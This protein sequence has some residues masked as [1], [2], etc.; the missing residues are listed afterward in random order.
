ML[1][2]ATGQARARGIRWLVASA[3]PP[4]HRSPNGK[5]LTQHR[6]P[7]PV[8]SSCLLRRRQPPSPPPT[9]ELPSPPLTVV[10]AGAESPSSPPAT[11]PP[12]PPLASELPSPP[13][14]IE[15]TS[16][17]PT[18]VSAG[19]ESP[20]PPPTVVST[21][22]ESPDIAA[23][24]PSSSRHP[25][26]CLAAAPYPSPP[27]RR[28]ALSRRPTA[29]LATRP[30]SRA[31]RGSV[32]PPRG[33]QQFS[34]RS[35]SEMKHPRQNQGEEVSLALS[36]STDSS[37][38][39]SA[40]LASA[41]KARRGPVVATSG[42][43]EFVCKTCS[44]AFASFQALGGHRTSHLRGRNGLDLGVVGDKALR[45]HRD[46]HEC[47]ICGLGFEMGQALGGHMRRHREEM[48][49]AGSSADEWVWRP[50]EVAE[51]TAE[52]PVLLEL[53]A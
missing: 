46:K 28:A 34:K 17:P 22:A 51:H 31:R 26:A 7:P 8:L 10:S 35:S 29:R 43:G 45:Q 50:E 13:P 47:H 52:P 48:A 41:K 23:L 36:L 37:T 14:T 25:E 12:S 2:R 15:L 39:S 3:T 6:S 18:I 33:I 21:G 32:P 9:I 4:V 16:P 20:S 30:Q 19:A 1:Q 24:V 5:T 11:S 44:R 53:F 40:R 49:G 38:D 27:V 42:E